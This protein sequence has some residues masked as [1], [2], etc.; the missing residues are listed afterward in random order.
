M[1]VGGEKERASTN[2]SIL[3]TCEGNMRGT[4]GWSRSVTPR[5]RIPLQSQMWGRIRLK[6]RPLPICDN[7]YNKVCI[8]AENAANLVPTFEVGVVIIITSSVFWLSPIQH[9]IR[10]HFNNSYSKAQSWKPPGAR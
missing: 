7:K 9:D 1:G 4:I 2:P 5:P 10:R 8:V 6:G 3:I